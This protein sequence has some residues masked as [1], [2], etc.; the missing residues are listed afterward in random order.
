[1]TDVSSDTQITM[2]TTVC[3]GP[4]GCDLCALDTPNTHTHTLHWA[5]S[6]GLHP[7]T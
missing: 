2:E 1:M 3:V 7:L 5:G 4:E 6:G